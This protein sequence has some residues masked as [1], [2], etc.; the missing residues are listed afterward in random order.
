[1]DLKLGFELEYE[2]G[3][4]LVPRSERYSLGL[5]VL[6]P[7]L[8]LDFFTKRHINIEQIQRFCIKIL[9]SIFDSLPTTGF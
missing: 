4:E 5:L 1:M 6:G 9:Q 2:T 7:E 3:D 8:E